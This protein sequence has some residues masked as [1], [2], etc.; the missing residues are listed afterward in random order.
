MPEPQPATVREFADHATL[1]LLESPENLR[2]LLRLVATEV[3]ERLDFRRAERLNRSIIPDSLQKQEADLL[4]RVPYRESK[5]EVWIYLLVEHQSRPDRLM[6]L[7]LLSY[8]V[9]I[10]ETQVRGWEDARTPKG[11]RRLHPIVP[12]VFYTGRRRWSSPLTLQAV[13]EAPGELARF[14]PV[15]E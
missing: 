11:Q 6:G 1:W 10:W 9:Q 14:I 15:F 2:E 13:M 3:A 12:M 8:M 7:R 5:R 4:F